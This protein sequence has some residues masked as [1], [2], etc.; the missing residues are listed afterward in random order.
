MDLCWC[1]A[2]V[3]LSNLLPQEHQGIAASLV[4][5]VVNYS[6]SIGLGVAGT[7]DAYVD[8]DQTNRL[9]GYRSAL[10]TGIGFSGLAVLVA[11]YMRMRINRLVATKSAQ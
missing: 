10:Y 4:N 5:T 7:V 3:T 11:A 9:L 8:P 1:S 6:I 2:S